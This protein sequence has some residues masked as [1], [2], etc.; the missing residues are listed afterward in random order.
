[1]II[2]SII[3]FFQGS[4][5]TLEMNYKIIEEVCREPLVL[6]Q[7]EKNGRKTKWEGTRS[8]WNPW[9]EYGFPKGLRKAS[10]Y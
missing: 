8:F 6:I 3:I 7:F 4:P 1:M 2:F 10:E 5:K 9:V